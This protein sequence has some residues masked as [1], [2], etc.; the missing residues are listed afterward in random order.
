[1]ATQ[2]RNIDFGDYATA[3][4][5]FLTM[6]VMPFTYSITNGIGA[7]FVSYVVIRL[8]QGKARLVHPLMWVV[9]AL[10]VVYFA[11]APLERLL[12]VR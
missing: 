9:A 10:F 8:A 11:L 6:V 2:V 5:A 7:G 1:M 4:P 3:V 12:G